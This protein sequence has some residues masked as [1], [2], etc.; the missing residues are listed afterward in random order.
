[1]AISPAAS[2]ILVPSIKHKATAPVRDGLSVS[3]I[4]RL[5]WG[6]AEGS[7]H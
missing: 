7:Q 5:G 4:Y 3:S 1:M 2:F 6:R